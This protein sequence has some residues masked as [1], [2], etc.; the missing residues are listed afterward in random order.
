MTD[1][2]LDSVLEREKSTSTD[3]GKGFAIPHGLSEYVNHSAAVFASLKRPIVW[4]DDGETVD[5]V[6]LLAFDLSEDAEVKDEIIGFY[7][8]IVTFM[9]NDSECERLKKL[10]D[11]KDIMEILEKW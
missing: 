7:K 8:S 6:F 9:E 10:S 1:G 4:S 5:T 3:I 2:F 11:N